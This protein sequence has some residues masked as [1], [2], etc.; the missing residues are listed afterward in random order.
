M[1]DTKSRTRQR[2]SEQGQTGFE[3][4]IP[5]EV[6]YLARLMDAKY[7]FPGTNW[8]FGLDPILGLIP[9]IG[10]FVGFLISGGIILIISRHG[11]SGKLLTLMVLNS[12][13]DGLIGSIPVLGGIIDFFYKNNEKNVKMLE[14]HYR[15]G[16]YQG[17]GKGIIIGVVLGLLALAVFLIWAIWEILEWAFN[18]LSSIL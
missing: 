5:G 14:E 12:F 2:S 13:L 6:I 7:K 3:K 4:K 16:K 8:R 1:Q 15:E 18:Y 10:D 11:A 9:G 17:S